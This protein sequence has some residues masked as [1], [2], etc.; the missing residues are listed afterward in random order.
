MLQN[1]IVSNCKL[2]SAIIF[3]F[4]LTSTFILFSLPIPP[5]LECFCNF[6]GSFFSW[7]SHACSL[8][9]SVLIRQLSVHYITVYASIS[10]YKLLSVLP[11]W[12][13]SP[14]HF[15]HIFLSSYSQLIILD[16]HS[17]HGSITH[18]SWCCSIVLSVHYITVYSGHIPADPRIHHCRAAHL[19]R[20]QIH[21]SPAADSPIYH[22]LRLLLKSACV[23]SRADIVLSQ[24]N[25]AGRWPSVKNSGGW[26]MW[27]YKRN[28]NH[29]T[30]N[31]S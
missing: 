22:R 16:A 3:W 12:F 6:C 2:L 31:L 18:V 28:I 23:I 17:S 24:Q 29:K 20:Q 9:Y 30:E 19:T 14:I 11:F 13:L 15:F 1:Q 5:I 8:C 4:H 21:M 10:A 25:Y 7:F 26:N 27:Y